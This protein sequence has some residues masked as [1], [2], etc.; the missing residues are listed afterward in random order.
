M[1]KKILKTLVYIFV[2]MVGF[3]LGLIA[4]SMFLSV[5]DV[6]T[7][8]PMIG[9]ASGTISGSLSLFDAD[10]DMMDA[11]PIFMIIS[12][13]VLLVGLIIMAIDASVK[14]KTKKQIKGLNFTA[15][16][17]SSVGFILL[18]VSTIVTK[19]AVKDSMNSII[20]A[21]TKAE[22]GVSGY[23]DQELLMVINMFV[24]YKFGAGAI[25]AIIGGVIALIGSVLLVIPMFDPA[26]ASAS[27]AAQPAAAEQ[28]IEEFAQPTAAAADDSA[29]NIADN[30]NN[31]ANA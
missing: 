27:P 22:P 25:M 31:D 24:T 12:F 21:A 20:L 7:L 13:S 8:L 14:Q 6:K 1:E 9:T 2:S 15:L 29:N 4:V 16:G 11:S 17:I 19:G 3:G 28:P 10:W 26:N 5:I 18:I 30:D 23:S